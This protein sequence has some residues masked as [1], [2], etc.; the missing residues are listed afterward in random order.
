MSLSKALRC[1][2]GGILSVL[3]IGGCQKYEDVPG[4][5]DPRLDRKY[6]NDPEAVNFN[7]DFPGTADNSV[8]Y[9]PADVFAGTYSFIDSVY[10]SANKMAFS[11]QLTLAVQAQGHGKFD[12]SGFCSGNTLHFTVNRTLKASA[13]STVPNGHTLCRVQ[14][15]VSGY[16]IRKLGDS[17]R[18]HVLLTVVSDTGATIHQGTAYKQ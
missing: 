12:L 18:L 1:L 13:D 16:L 2:I 4:Q 10:T 17:T 11:K 3:L 15:T 7:F 6:C 8:C 9:Y 5:Y 14:D